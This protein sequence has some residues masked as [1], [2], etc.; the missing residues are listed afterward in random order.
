ML[1]LG[2]VLVS[3]HRASPFGAVASVH[4]WERVGALLC[5]IARC[6]LRL[7]IFRYVDDFFAPEKPSLMEH[8]M[9]CFARV[10]RVLLGKSAIADRK[11]E[12]G[13]ELVVLGVQ[14]AS[15]HQGFWCRPAKEKAEKCLATIEKVMD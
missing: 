4:S 13:C 15:T 3:W 5:K 11:L 14:M 8:A 2:Q 6:T 7:A 9:N 1:S 12:C 10:V